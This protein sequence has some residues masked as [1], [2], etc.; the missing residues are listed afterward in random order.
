MINDTD[1]RI[2]YPG[3]IFKRRND[4]TECGLSF[5]DPGEELIDASPAAQL[6]SRQIRHPRH[7]EAVG[8]A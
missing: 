1:Q 6:S 2:H 5:L 8:P 3:T 4:P 7:R